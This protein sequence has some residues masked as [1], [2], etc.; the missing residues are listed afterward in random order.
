MAYTKKKWVN[1][2]DPSNLPVIPE[3]QDALARF[4]AENMNRIEDGVEQGAV[5]IN[6]RT[7]TYTEHS[8]LATLTSGEKLSVAFGKIKRAVG[9]FISHQSNKTNPHEVSAAQIGALRYYTS[10]SAMNKDLGTN[11]DS[12]TPVETIINAMPLET[13]L[14]ADIIVNEIY[15]SEYG[16]LTIYK[17][18]PNRVNVEFLSSSTSEQNEYNERWVGQYNTNTFGGFQRVFTSYNKPSGS[19]T[20]VGNARTVSIGGQGFV[21]LIHDSSNMYLVSPRGYFYGIEDNGYVKSKDKN[22]ANFSGGE[23]HLAYNN[24]LNIEGRTYYYQ[25]L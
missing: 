13:G 16:L 14:V 9:E 5:P 20:G 12:N 15:P 24:I 7:P 8:T 3:G 6:D 21:I 1:V 4:D 11:F 10:F 2:D 22:S 25:V 23:L 17:I 18:R 19:Y